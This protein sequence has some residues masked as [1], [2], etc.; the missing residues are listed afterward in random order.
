MNFSHL[1]AKLRQKLSN[2]SG[3]LTQGLDKTASRFINEALSGTLASQ[4]VL[5][6]EIEGQLKSHVALKKIEVRFSR[7]LKK[8]RIWHIIHKHILLLASKHIK[9]KSLLIF[10]F[11]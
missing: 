3:I 9:D 8:P 2:F 10:G 11:E 7:Q 5:L 1:A 4:P 6:T